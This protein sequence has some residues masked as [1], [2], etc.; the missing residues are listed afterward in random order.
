MPIQIYLLIAILIIITAL[1]ISLEIANARRVANATPTTPT[2][3]PPAV[4]NM[5]EPTGK[6]RGRAARRM[7]RGTGP[8]GR[9][10]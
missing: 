1:F 7:S 4:V 8:M 10:L 2:A 3:P 5:P 6:A 9:K